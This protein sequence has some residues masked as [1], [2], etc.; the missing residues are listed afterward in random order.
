MK[1]IALVTGATSGLGAA[2]ATALAQ[3]NF[4]VLIAGR[5]AARGA[6]VVAQIAARGGEAEFLA[7]DLFTKGGILAL[8]EQ[9]KRRTKTLAVLV[10]NAGGSFQARQSTA[11]QIERTFA[12]NTLAPFLLSQALLPELSAARGRIVNVATG[13]P[14]GTKVQLNQLIDPPKYSGFSAYSNAKLALIAVTIEQATRYA[15]QGITAVSLH[16]GIILGTR[17]GQDIPKPVLA[18]MGVVARV[19]R[20][21][22]SLEQATGRF[23]QAATGTAQTGTFFDQGKTGTPPQQTQDTAFRSELWKLLEERSR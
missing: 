18:I 9:V 8:A 15:G 1:P 19:F 10:N 20:M 5:D 6:E 3:A 11:D 23:L 12:L 13:V 4:H 21:N 7:A 17:F 14:K 2:A 16:P 22:S